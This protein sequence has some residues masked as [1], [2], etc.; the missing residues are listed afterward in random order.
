MTRTLLITGTSKGIGEALARHYLNLGWNVAG[1]SRGGGAIEHAAYRH[2]S[3]EVTDEAAVVKMVRGVAREFGR[4][5]ALINNAG[6][7]AMNHLLT[8]PA[9]AAR[10]IVETNFLGTL[11]FL[12]EA[13]K[14]MAR[15][16]QGRIVNLST[17]AVPLDLEGEAVYA[18]SKAAVESLTRI[19]AREFGPLGI[20]VNALGPAPIPTDLT[21]A[22]PQDKLAAL[23]ARQ[24][25]P[26]DGEMRDVTNVTDFFLN[27]R[28]DFITGQIIYLGGVAP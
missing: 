7:A 16:K 6:T 15:Q 17:V 24:A 27:E 2:F 1:C 13:A 23:V 18:A 14:I 10:R 19:A 3:L 28:S 9:S 12:R 4:L 5:D 20:C 11:L 8:T 22:V 26:R 21:R 25:I